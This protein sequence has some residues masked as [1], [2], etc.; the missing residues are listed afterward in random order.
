M[1]NIINRLLFFVFVFTI[2]HSY[3]MQEWIRTN[4]QNIGLTQP[5]LSPTEELKQIIE[6]EGSFRNTGLQRLQQLLGMQ[7]DATVMVQ[8]GMHSGKTPLLV[9]IADYQQSDVQTD[10]LLK[11]RLIAEFA[12][13]DIN[14]PD[15][16]G[17]TP[18][19]V[20]AYGGKASLIPIL[21]RFGADIHTRDSQGDTPLIITVTHAANQQDALATAKKLL[22]AGVDINA[23]NKAGATALYR[24]VQRKKYALIQFLVENGANTRLATTQGLTP[25]ALAKANNDQQAVALLSETVQKLP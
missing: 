17:F 21:L 1:K 5:K 8:G 18:L 16:R 2:N 15:E 7:A 20:A 19:A 24:A 25:L 12:K 11:V 10:E 22:V 9:A 3:A 6:R 23:Q 4:L 14:K 13:A